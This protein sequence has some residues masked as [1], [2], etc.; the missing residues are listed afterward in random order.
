MKK[1][2]VFE[3][4]TKLQDKIGRGQKEADRRRGIPT[5]DDIC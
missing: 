2:P 1:L 5:T 3:P 4:V